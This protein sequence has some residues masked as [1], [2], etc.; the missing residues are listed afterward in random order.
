MRLAVGEAGQER[1]ELGAGEGPLERLGDLAV[2]LLEG[3]DA[4]GERVEV[5]EVVGRQRLALQDRE[6]DLD[7]VQPR[8]VDGQVDQPRVGIGVLRAASIERW[9]A[10]LE[11]LS[12]IQNTR[13]APT[14]RARCS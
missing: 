7:L 12:T 1:V 13:L 10:W 3:G 4:G 9:P 2:V 6:V 5:G 14:R 8:G 11:P